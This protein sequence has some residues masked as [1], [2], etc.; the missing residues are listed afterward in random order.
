MTPFVIGLTVFWVLRSYTSNL[1]DV[2]KLDVF[3][4]ALPRTSSLLDGEDRLLGYIPFDQK[5]VVGHRWVLEEADWEERFKKVLLAA[6]DRRF[7]QHEGVDVHAVLR[8]FR[9]NAEAGKTV[10]G[11]S[12]ITQQL[13]RNIVPE[14]GNERTLRRKIR[15]AIVSLRLEKLYSKDE[16]LRAYAN[17]VFLG[18]QAYGI[19]TASALFFDKE[20]GELSLAEMALLAGQIQAPSRTNPFKDLVAARKRRNQVLDKCELYGWESSSDV[21]DAKEEVIS[22]QSRPN[23]LGQNA[24]WQVEYVRQAL[25]E[26]YKTELKKGGLTIKTKIDPDLERELQ[27]I[28]DEHATELNPKGPPPNL[29]VMVVDYEAGL[30]KAMIGGTSFSGDVFN[31][32]TQ[33]CRQPGSAFKPLVYGAAL[34]LGRITPAT[35]LRDG[36]IAM[37]DEDMKLFWKPSNSG[38]SFKG[39][40]VAH[41]ALAQ[42]LNTPTIEVF[43]KIGAEAVINF[44]KKLGITSRLVSVRPLALGASCVPMN[45]LLG[46][47]AT[48]ANEGLQ[49]PFKLV[50]LL[51]QNGTELFRQRWPKKNATELSDEVIDSKRQVMDERVAFQLKAMLRSAVKRGTGVA[52]KKLGLPA[53]GK[54]GTTNGN[55]DA[56]FVGFTDRHVAAVW[57]GHDDPATPL[58]RGQD[59]SHAALPLWV[60]IMKAVEGQREAGE[61]LANPPDGLTKARIDMESGDLAGRGP[62]Q[63]LF[64]ISGTEPTTTAIQSAG[65]DSIDFSRAADSY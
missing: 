21:K 32:A 10:E 9:S 29:A 2:P 63:E 37:W 13:A 41:D 4:D 28:A 31:R 39:M 27:Q 55:T 3:Y 6:E 26:E 45:E 44:S 49:H 30:I 52:A 34:S 20:P 11:A 58:G 16:I 18:H 50:D 60:K 38:R 5:S 42:S 33:A 57:I 35:Q 14:I 36:P 8:A 15:E 54:T 61:I 24:P 53:A 1:P 25:I 19:K 17:F 64:F 51:E 48:I 59:G 7:Y 23:P 40:A 46:V 47:Y 22:L 65:V 43:D 62:G 56:W 12:T